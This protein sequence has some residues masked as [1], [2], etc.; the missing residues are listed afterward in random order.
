MRFKL[1]IPLNFIALIVANLAVAQNKTV[2]EKN[3]DS[4]IKIGQP[5]KI[6]PYLEKE[7]KK[8]PKNESLLR[9]LG[10]YHLQNN[11]LAEGE[12]FYRTALSINPKCARCYLN[13][14]RLQAIKNEGNEALV[15]INKAIS[16]DAKDALLF[17][18]RAKIKAQFGDQFGALADYNKAIELAP[19]N[20]EYYTE[21]G[22]YNANNSY[23]SLALT[24]F[25][26][27]I[28][29]LPE[30]YDA[31][32]YRGGVYN[33]QN[34]TEDA[35]TDINKAILLNN[36]QA[37][38]YDGRAAIYANLG[39]FDKA[40]SDYSQSIKLNPK[41]YPAYINRAKV[42]Y[43]LE[44][45]DA[46]CRDYSTAKQI[47]INQKINDAELLKTIDESVADFC[48]EAKPS[49]YYQR[50]IAHYNLK[51]YDKALVQYAKGLQ[52]F[53]KNAMM[54][55]FKGNAYLALTDYKNAAEN[56]KAS[57]ENKENLLSEIKSN[58]RFTAATTAEINGYYNSSLASIY[59]G[60]SDCYANAEHFE[61]AFEAINTAIAL[62]PD[63]K[64]FEKETYFNRRG[65]IYLATEKYNLALSDFNK[66][67]QLKND[68]APAYVNRAVAR[69]SLTENI[70][71]TTYHINTK[72]ANQPA[73][74]NWVVNN[75][76]AIKK[77]ESSLLSAL[78]DCNKAIEL[79]KNFAFAYYVRGSI[80]QI[81]SQ[82]D[83]CIDILTA[84][85]MGFEIDETMLK[86]CNQ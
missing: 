63:I 58:P 19:N 9:L 7:L 49:Y 16:I 27:A 65:N 35:L 61:V 23:H 22:A 79:D 30:A 15:S 82:Q 44:N 46:S 39:Q 24:D 71:K 76:S 73:A 81:L 11:N 54:F 51:E 32:Y 77:S 70:K 40:L 69:V 20:A 75:K 21:R 33:S 14:S 57:L 60:L 52:K 38:F 45:L 41:T 67:I 68:Y 29:L 80:K 36:K 5:E 17:S 53:P 10:F 42:Y 25:N 31:Y 6:I 85:K 64:S 43:E 4:L 56:Y 83:F 26:K 62:A 72:I 47:L 8:T 28:S 50:G 59:S 86:N 3:A 78:A 18:T 55:S 66:S 13:I 37:Y 12:K 1:I 84:K 2:F 74:I 48:D 34:K